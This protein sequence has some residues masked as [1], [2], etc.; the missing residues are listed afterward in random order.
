M[1]S[2]MNQLFCSQHVITTAFVSRGAATLK[3]YETEVLS[4]RHRNTSLDE[5]HDFETLLETDPRVEIKS[6]MLYDCSA[7]IPASQ[8]R[9]LCPGTALHGSY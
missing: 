2:D 8:S 6:S 4:N 5:F 9:G 3:N 1:N 7:N